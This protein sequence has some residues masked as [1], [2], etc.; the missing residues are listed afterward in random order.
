VKK[1]L[2]DSSRHREGSAYT[3]PVNDLT[4]APST[5]SFEPGDVWAAHGNAEASM[6]AATARPVKKRTQLRMALFSLLISV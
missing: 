1:V 4:M 2:Q 3:S 5:P 6:L